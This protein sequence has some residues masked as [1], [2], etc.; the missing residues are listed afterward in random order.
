MKPWKFLSGTLL[1]LSLFAQAQEVKK[2]KISG[3]EKIM[4]K[5]DAVYVIN[6]W[7]TWCRPC[8]EEIPYLEK[9]AQQYQDQNVQ[10]I[11]VS[12][13]FPNAYPKRINA[14]ARKNNLHAQLFWLDESNA[15]YFAPK[16]DP[17]WS[18]IIPCT[19]FINNKKH[20]RRFVE[21]QMTAAQFEALLQT[22]L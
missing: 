21:Q 16:I 10:L 14:F 1:L 20:Y 8:I 2:I 19:L 6:F 18:G 7:A 12:L 17:N 11:L 9:I 5:E 15:N 13:D 22:A 3:L 4:K